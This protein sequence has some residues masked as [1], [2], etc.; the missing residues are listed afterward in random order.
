MESHSKFV[1]VALSKPFVVPAKRKLTWRN[2]IDQQIYQ[3]LKKQGPLTRG[4]L[5][6]R[7]GLPRTTLY[8][9][10]TRLSVRGLIVRFTEPRQSRGRRRVF[11]EVATNGLS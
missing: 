11:F 7:T 8:D 6:E 1:E 10:L 2:P 9:A 3:L 4:E 5:V